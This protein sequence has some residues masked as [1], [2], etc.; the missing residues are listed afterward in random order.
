MLEQLF[1]FLKGDYAQILTI[2]LSVIGGLVGLRQWIKGN[3][4]KRAAI[5]KELIAE[6]RDDREI[7]FIMD[8]VDWLDGFYYNGIFHLSKKGLN[9]FDNEKQLFV[10]IDRTLAHA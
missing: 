6:V 10:A 5:V 7:A 8:A 3:D 1:L 4:Y 2:T 9:G